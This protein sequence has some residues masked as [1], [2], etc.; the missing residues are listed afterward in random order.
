[1]EELEIIKKFQNG[2]ISIIDLVDFFGNVKITINK[3]KHYNID[4]LDSDIELLKKRGME[5]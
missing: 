2:Y 4:L 5:K 1:M 3:L